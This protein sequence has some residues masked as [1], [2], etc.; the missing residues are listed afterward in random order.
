[1]QF[2]RCK[3]STCIIRS[4]PSKEYGTSIP[5]RTGARIRS[6]E[7]VLVRAFGDETSLYVMN[8]SS[9]FPIETKG[10]VHWRKQGLLDFAPFLLA[11]E[12]LGRDG[13]SCRLC[14]DT[15]KQ[16]L[17]G[18]ISKPNS[19]IH[20]TWVCEIRSCVQPI[21]CWRIW[22]F[23]SGIW[24]CLAAPYEH[25]MHISEDLLIREP[26]GRKSCSASRLFLDEDV[27]KSA[28]VRS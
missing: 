17:T 7:A 27:D 24:W 2:S 4:R 9:G 13:V 11:S 8:R 14:L 10:S 18:N 19:R 23:A 20:P 16:S 15:L 21:P 1:M 6:P 22:K 26:F 28:V 5:K 12:S 3:A 25:R